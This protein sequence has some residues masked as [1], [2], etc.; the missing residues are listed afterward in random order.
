[1]TKKKRATTRYQK[2]AGK[3]DHQIQSHGDTHNED[4]EY[5]VSER[6]HLNILAMMVKHRF[7][8]TDKMKI[9]ATLA[10]ARRVASRND[11]VAMKAA[12]LIKEFDKLNQA[13]EHHNETLPLPP[14]EPDKHLHIHGVTVA[15]VINDLSTHPDFIA[16]AKRRLERGNPGPHGANGNS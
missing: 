9:D 14:Q 15:E 16:V 11:R 10:V 8:I 6:E 4:D 2:H 5:P 3:V 13:D 12:H 1:M 7:P